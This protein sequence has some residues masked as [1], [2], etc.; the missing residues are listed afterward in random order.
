MYL[1][2]I[3]KIKYP[4]ND[5]IIHTYTTFDNLCNDLKMM[6]DNKFISKNDIIRIEVEESEKVYNEFM[7]LIG[8]LSNNEIKM[9]IDNLKEYVEND[10]LFEG[11]EE[12]E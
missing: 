3:T 1:L 5:T 6:L 10:E 9:L 8:R 12:D 7:G 2:S 11:D 4:H